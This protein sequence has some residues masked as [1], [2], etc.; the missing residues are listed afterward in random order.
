M[1]SRNRQ[2]PSIV[3]MATCMPLAAVVDSR[4][5]GLRDATDGFVVAYLD[6]DRWVGGRW[7]DCPFRRV[8][9]E[10]IERSEV[11][12]DMFTRWFTRPV[13]RCAYGVVRSYR[14][15]SVLFLLLGGL[16]GSI[17]T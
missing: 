11:P 5:D 9:D 7:F 17:V 8:T 3:T 15:R 13:R 6:R 1:N 2:F 16:H 10:E 4:A 12:P 14:S